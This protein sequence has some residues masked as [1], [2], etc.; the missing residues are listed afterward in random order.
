[1]PGRETWAPAGYVAYSKV[2]RTPAARSALR[3]Q[4]QLLVCPCHQS[5]FDVTNGAV[6]KFGPAPRPLPQLPLQITSDGY[7]VA[8]LAT[9]SPWALATGSATRA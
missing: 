6:P 8:Q 7:L 1:M 2:A 3:A 5:M 4:L 9:I